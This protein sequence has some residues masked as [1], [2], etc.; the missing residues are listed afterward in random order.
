MHA[1][2]G[3]VFRC[4]ADDDR[5]MW[6]IRQLQHERIAGDFDF[7]R[8]FVERRDFLAKIFGL[9]L[10]SFRLSQFLLAH[11][12]ADFLRHLVAFGF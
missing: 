5:F 4:F 1:H 7:R 6:Q 3:I 10:F 8:R 2:F 11:Q 9:R 12:R